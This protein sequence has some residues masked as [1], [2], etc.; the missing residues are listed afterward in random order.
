L[1]RSIVAASFRV[2]RLGEERWDPTSSLVFEK[3]RD[4]ASAMDEAHDLEVFAID[5]VEDQVGLEAIHH[6]RPYALSAG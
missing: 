1:P 5:A 6:P 3:P 4:V 2:Q